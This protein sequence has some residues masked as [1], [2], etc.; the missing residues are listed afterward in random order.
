MVSER[1]GTMIASVAA[2]FAG[3]FDLSGVK[4]PAS[5]VK[6]IAVAWG[7]FAELRV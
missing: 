1:L 2:D 3:V 7:E 4:R 6:V 5:R